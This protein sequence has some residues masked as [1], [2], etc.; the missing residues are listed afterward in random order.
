MQE[1]NPVSA[2]LL[3]FILL[4]GLKAHSTVELQNLHKCLKI[5][6]Q[7]TICLL[8]AIYMFLL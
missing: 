4:Y 2:G 5:L 7:P 1:Q 8:S 3:V 6:P